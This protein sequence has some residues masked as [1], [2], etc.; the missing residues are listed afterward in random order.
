[1]EVVIPDREQAGAD[2]AVAGDADAA[3]VAA[4]GMGNGSDDADLA[5]AIVEA[6]AAR[7]FRSC[8]PNFDE[9]T[10]LAHAHENFVE[11]NDRPRRPGAAFFQRHEFD[12]AHG[13][14]LFAGEHAEGNDLVSLKPRMS[15]Q[16]TF[17]GQ[18]P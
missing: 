17:S 2:F 7:G 4:E 15:T 12:E 16:F 3:A 11:S 13:D 1:M 9:R 10:V 5:D 6:V 18:S 8:P 14:A